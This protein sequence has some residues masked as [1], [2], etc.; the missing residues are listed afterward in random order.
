MFNPN[1]INADMIVILGYDAR[2]FS[3]VEETVQLE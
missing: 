2:A 1:I 3:S